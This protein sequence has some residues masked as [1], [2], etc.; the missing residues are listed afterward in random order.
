MKL[1]KFSTAKGCAWR[2]L[3]INVNGG[4]VFRISLDPTHSHGPRLNLSFGLANF[5]NRLPKRLTW[6]RPILWHTH[7]D[8]ILPLPHL[9]WKYQGSR[10][11]NWLAGK[12]TSFWFSLDGRNFKG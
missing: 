5:V 6:L 4:Q 1:I 9:R 10:A 3:Y 11:R 8:I 2:A 7:P 12:S